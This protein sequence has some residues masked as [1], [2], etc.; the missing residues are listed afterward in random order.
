MK[1]AVPMISPCRPR[2]TTFS[3]V[4]RITN[5]KASVPTVSTMTPVVGLIDEASFVDPSKAA[6]AVD[7]SMSRSVSPASS[8]PTIWKLRYGT[9]RD[10][11]IFPETAWATVTAGLMWAEYFP[12]VMI[13][14]ATV[15]P[16]DSAMVPRATRGL[17]PGSSDNAMTVP[18][19]IR[20]NA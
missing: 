8:P 9:S 20:T 5:T 13:T 3:V 7:P 4:N 16:N 18:G 12:S 2:P 19:P 1:S 15:A 6:E 10:L 14:P 11:L 17:T